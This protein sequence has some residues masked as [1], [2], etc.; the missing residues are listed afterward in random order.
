MAELLRLE[1]LR[2]G[3]GQ[4]V[5]V[6]GVDLSLGEGESLALLGRNG[7]GKTTLLNT[8]VGVTRRHAGHRFVQQQ[9]ARLAGQRRGDLEQPALAVGEVLDLLVHHVGQAE[10]RQ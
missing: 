4:A 6:Q 7:T 2:S 9:H 5:V 1:G 10:L 8:L 3:Y